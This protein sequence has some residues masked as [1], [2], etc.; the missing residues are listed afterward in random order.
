[1]NVDNIVY[2]HYYV[3]LGVGMN[4]LSKEKLGYYKNKK[5]LSN[6]KLAELSGL[7]VSSVDKVFSG[8]NKNPT[9]ET[10]K[11][12]ADVLDV[13]ID[14]FIDYEI[15]PLAGYYVD[16]QTK[17]VAKALKTNA[18]LKELFDIAADL[19]KEDL[20]LITVIVKRMTCK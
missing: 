11:K 3:V 12:I 18:E 6:V 9:L 15:E 13:S 5:G 20:K 1:M 14:D 19:S 17:K 2:L 4:S 10:L 7:T 8:L 16:R